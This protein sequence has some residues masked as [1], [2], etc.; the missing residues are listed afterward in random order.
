MNKIAALVSG[1][2]L[3]MVGAPAIALT[4]P[5]PAFSVDD[6]SLI[7]RTQNIQ[8]QLGLSDGMILSV[9]AGNGYSDIRITKKKLTK[10]Q[11]QGCR[12]GKRYKVEISMDGRIRKAVQIG[13][14][15]LPINPQIARKIL[16]QKGY[17]Q[18]FI[19]PEGNRF[20]VVA[21]R[22]NR[23]F[24][25]VMD[26]FGEIQAE[27]V[28]G[29]CGGA[30]SEYDV[31]ALLRAQGYSR[32]DVRRGPRGNYAAEVC[33]GDDRLG[34][35]VNRSGGIVREKR[36]GRC[37]PP[38]H[39]AAIPSLLAG[40]GFSRIEVVDRKLPRYLAHACRGNTRL[41]IALNRFGEIR[42]ERPIGRCDPPL[43]GADLE[44]KLR[45]AG[46]TGVKILDQRANGFTAEVCE[47]A[48]L[49]RLELT[50]FGET[51]TQTPLGTCPTRPIGDVVQ[52]FERQ[53]I[54]QP[55][56][57]IEG[58]RRGRRVRIELDRT[59]EEVDRRVIGRCR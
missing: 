7:V 31:A 50:I 21:C 54:S 33:R 30:L 53:G 46:F 19:Q 14:C 38:I 32:I 26:V 1:L 40:Y 42:D 20:A 24:R 4:L 22:A 37:D 5:A 25:I 57:F 9:M 10:A 12:D 56:L 43:T 52:D 59:G 55:T 3:F 13:T 49:L 35:V 29:R 58:C 18:I 48:T 23:R 2:L 41:E 11:A 16:R 36:I 44:Q 8:F 47:D 34:L 15:R 51:V 45:D 17:S 39:P 27:K 6:H 28:L